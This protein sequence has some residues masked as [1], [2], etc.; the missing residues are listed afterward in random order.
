[1]DVVFMIYLVIFF[2]CFLFLAIILLVFKDYRELLVNYLK[3][4]FHHRF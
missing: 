2:V 4:Y 3:N 1:M